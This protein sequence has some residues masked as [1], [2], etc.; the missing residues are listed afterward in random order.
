MIRNIL[1]Y[2]NNVIGTLELPDDTP[3][4]VWQNKLQLYMVSPSDNTGM[5][6]IAL[7]WLRLIKLR[8]SMF[9]QTEWLKLRHRDQ[10]DR[11][12]TTSLTS[13]QYIEWLNY[14]Q[15]LRD[16]NLTTDRENRDPFSIVFP[17]QP[18]L[19]ES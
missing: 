9:L 7:E 2:Q 16:L 11:G 12:T 5:D 14:W 1:D 6:I 13:E 3:E 17:E 18:T 8:E 19:G 4:D 15:Y 10:I